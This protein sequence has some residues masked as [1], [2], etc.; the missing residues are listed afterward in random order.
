MKIVQ[1]PLFKV[2]IFF[3]FGIIFSH[4]FDFQ[5]FNLL[6]VLAC[7]MLLLVVLFRLK[8]KL[9]S[10]LISLTIFIS[11][12][13]IGLLSHSIHKEIN[14]KKHY[15]HSILKDKGESQ[16]EIV[17]IE[18]LKDSPTNFRY[19]AEVNQLNSEPKCGKILLNINNETE[20]KRITIG[21][22]LLLSGSIYKN[23]KPKN[24]DQF[25]Y[26][27]YLENQQVYG[28][29][30][31][32]ASEVK[33]SAEISKSFSFYAAEL[34]NKIISNLENKGFHKQELS[35]VV[36]LILGQQQEISPEILHDYQFAGAIHVLSVSGLHVG[37]IL[38]FLT[39][40][41]KPIP[42]TKKGSLLK[43][44]ITLLGLWSFGVLAGLAPCVVRSITMFSFVAIALFLNR[45][46]NIYFSLLISGLLILLFQPSFLFDVG[47]QLSYL[48]LFFIVWLQPL[49]KTIYTP[50]NKIITYFWDII[51]VSFAAQIGTLPL[52]IYYFHQFPGLFFVTNL[53]VLP[54]LTLLLA[55]AIFVVLFAAFDVVWIPVIKTLE[56]GIWLLNKIINWI[57]SFERFIF[58]DIPLSFSMLLGLYL[59]FFTWIVWFK[60]P[61]FTKLSISFVSL[62][63]FQIICLNTKFNS[64][65][66][67]E[68][69]VFNIKKN[70]LISERNGENIIVFANDSLHGK[71][72]NNTNLKSYLV[73]NF[74]KVIKK[75]RMQNVYYFNKK[76]ILVINKY[77]TTTLLNAD[78]LL[79]TN[80]PKINLE[81]LFLNYKPEQVVCDGSNF[82][83]YVKL[84]KKSCEKLNIPFHDTTEKGFFKI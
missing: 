40:L 17:I 13:L 73:A 66:T 61:S 35:V 28:Q 64:E 59:V 79:L 11:S 41:L 75:K 81:R 29:F 60:K 21:S 4:Y 6:I 84:W 51:T 39:F 23:Q 3:V 43:L 16:I 62:I 82:K 72:E 2:T 80:S 44:F 63:V 38:T 26:S 48:A 67:T 78:V 1:F 83:S 8:F 54:G 27:K 70:T 12:F 76:K 47:F 68:F 55:L 71:I 58:K 50:K 24:P 52:N 42:N 14:N 53:I 33:I 5:V 7:S 46:S 9:K 19:I 18:K 56:S 15:I 20:I 36:A 74:C 34:R 49:L 22:H 10:I 31:T 25:D 32:S 30:Y 45:S 65:K 37:F 57:A 77:A 69:I